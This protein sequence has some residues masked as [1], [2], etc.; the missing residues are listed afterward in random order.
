MYPKFTKKSRSLLKIISELIAALKAVGKKAVE[1]IQALNLEARLKP[2]VDILL[3]ALALIVLVLSLLRSGGKK[4]IAEAVA[5]TLVFTQWWQNELEPDTLEKLIKEFEARRPEIKIVLNTRSYEETKELF[6]NYN[7]DIDDNSPAP[8]DILAVE[9]LWIPELEKTGLLHKADIAGAPLLSYFYPLFY[10]IDILREAGFSRPPKN[11]SEFLTFV[12]AVSNA[13]THRYG[14]ALSLSPDNS[15]NIYTDVYPWIWA[16]GAALLNE[17]RPALTQKAVIETLEFLA[18]LN[19]GGLVYP[20]PFSLGKDEKLNAFIK[21]RAAFMIGR[22]QDIEILKRELG[23]AHFSLSSIPPPD[24]Y[25]GKPIFGA[26]GWTLAPSQTGTHQEE[27]KAFISFLYEK[28]S[29]L[30][31]NAHVVPGAGSNPPAALDALYSKA[32]DIFI[33]GDLVQEFNH[34]EGEAKREEAFREE[35][36]KLF[37]DKQT[38]AETAAAI[39]KK[40]EKSQ[41]P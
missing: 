4:A 16:A 17:G 30:A 15:Q 20:R 7:P 29:I 23:A 40:W 6:L 3:L 9:P 18:N 33:A 25:S 8:G 26:S 2:H 28:K 19:R 21:G 41:T 14:I 5:P 12:Q 31:E 35:L 39:Q 36:S 24:S 38:A 11:R 34:A 10:N 22:V 13:E 1:K 37:E 27:A 32:W